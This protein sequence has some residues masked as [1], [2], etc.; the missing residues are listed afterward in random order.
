MGSMGWHMYSTAFSTISTI[1]PDAM[2]C[3]NLNAFAVCACDC[4]AP[5]KTFHAVIGQLTNLEEVVRD[6]RCLRGGVRQGLELGLQWRRS[7]WKLRLPPCRCHMRAAG[8]SAAATTARN[9]DR[10]SGAP[11]PSRHRWKKRAMHRSCA[12]LTVHDAAAS[13]S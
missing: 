7:R 8:E 9:V 1:S 6:G 13:T 10:R 5:L 11:S 2:Q 4:D 3:L 12:N